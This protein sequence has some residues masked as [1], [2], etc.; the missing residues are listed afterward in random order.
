MITITKRLGRIM[1]TAAHKACPGATDPVQ[2]TVEKKPEADF[3]CPTA[4]KYFNMTK[5]TGS[6]GFASCKDMAE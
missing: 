4:M 1:Q 5:K 2:I 6:Y 3:V